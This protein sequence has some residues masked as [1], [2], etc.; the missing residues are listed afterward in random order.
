MIVNT[1]FKRHKQRQRA[2]VLSWKERLIE[3]LNGNFMKPA[4][5]VRFKSM[6]QGVGN[7]FMLKKPEVEGGQVFST[8]AEAHQEWKKNWKVANV[9]VVQAQA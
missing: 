7:L 6:F 9:P 5:V 4:E 3:T 1:D 8:Q 2:Q